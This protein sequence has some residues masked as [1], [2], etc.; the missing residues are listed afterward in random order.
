M[1]ELK[2]KAYHKTLG[3]VHVLSIE[4]LNGLVEVSNGEKVYLF[5]LNEIELMQSTGICDKN[6]I[7]IYNGDIIKHFDDEILQVKWINDCARFF[8][9]SKYGIEREI[10]VGYE[11]CKSSTKNMEVI[12][13]MYENPELLEERK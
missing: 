3:V 13:N 4:F 12:G 5:T 1:K 7:E 6:G 2:L 10:P 9:I 8:A 11:L